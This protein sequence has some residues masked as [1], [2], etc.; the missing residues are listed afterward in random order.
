M[1]TDRWRR[2]EAL[3]L[4][5][6]ARPAPER[7][8]ALVAAC[9]GD[10]A[11][12]AEVQSLLDQPESAAGFLATPALELAAHLVPPASSQPQLEPGT[13]LGPYQIETLLGAGG[14]GRVFRARDTRLGRAVAI[15]VCL[16]GFSGRFEREAQSIAVS[17]PS[18]RLHALRCRPELPGDGIGRG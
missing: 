5:M 1:T 6:L 7:E 18:A 13:R 14:M 10:A 16:E 4:E 9:R 17:E 15:K 2:I 11:L 12:Q 3:Y 8:E